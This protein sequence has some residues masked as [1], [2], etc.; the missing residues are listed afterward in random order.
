MGVGWSTTEWGLLNRQSDEVVNNLLLRGHLH[1]ILVSLAW[2]AASGAQ[3]NLDKRKPPKGQLHGIS[4][5]HEGKLGAFL[6]F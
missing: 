5:A 1:K 3:Q 6:Q 2:M 4:G